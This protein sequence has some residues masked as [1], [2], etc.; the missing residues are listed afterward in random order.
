[1]NAEDFR[2]VALDQPEAEERSHLGKADF[3]V[4]N[5]IFASLP[6]PDLAVIKLTPAEQAV[7]CQAE[8]AVFRPVK[9]GWGRQGWTE[10]LLEMAD[11]QALLC[12]CR[13]GWRNAAPSSLR[14]RHEGRD[15]RLTL[16]SGRPGRPE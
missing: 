14:R 1:M 9:G 6:A 10:I 7:V 12:A 2:R 16:S 13:M 11:E 4:R 8:P 15:G 3:R 5:R